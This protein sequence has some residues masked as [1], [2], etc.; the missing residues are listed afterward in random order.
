MVDVK[1]NLLSIIDIYSGGGIKVLHGSN[2][3]LRPQTGHYLEQIES[4]M[5][6]YYDHF[7][8]FRFLVIFRIMYE[9]FCFQ[10]LNI[11]FRMDAQCLNYLLHVYRY[12]VL[13]ANSR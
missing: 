8:L 9:P 2:C 7:R 4:K 6:I 11:F 5:S 1:I 10:I 3:H 12:L 13:Q